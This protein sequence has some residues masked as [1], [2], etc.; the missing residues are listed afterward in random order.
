[1]ETT[2]EEYRELLRR[3]DWTYEFSEMSSVFRRGIEQRRQLESL[4][5]KL[6]PEYVIWNQ[7][8]PNFCKG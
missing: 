4:Q 8:A 2:I 5:E 1:M 7:F 3:H 6:D